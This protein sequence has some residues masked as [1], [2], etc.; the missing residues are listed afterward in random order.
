MYQTKGALK[1]LFGR[2]LREV[3]LPSPFFVPPWL[4]CFA[5]PSVRD[6]QGNFLNLSLLL[7]EK[8]ASAHQAQS[9][10]ISL[11]HLYAILVS[12][13]QVASDLSRSYMT[14]K[15]ECLDLGKLG[16]T[17]PNHGVLQCTPPQLAGRWASRL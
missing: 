13:S 1:P 14:K 2:G 6:L 12:L 11:M 10:L 3:C 4:G 5:P 16:K 17:T 9:T 7:L 8:L 15:S